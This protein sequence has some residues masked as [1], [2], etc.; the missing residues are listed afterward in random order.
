L[1]AADAQLQAVWSEA[2]GIEE[3]VGKRGFEPPTPGAPSAHK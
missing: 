3:L 2:T 1:N